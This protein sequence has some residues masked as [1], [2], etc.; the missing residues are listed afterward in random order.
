M[1]TLKES[2]LDDIETSMKNGDNLTK[3]GSHFTFKQLY[4]DDDNLLCINRS[5]L[6]SAIDGL[7]PFSDT[8]E[9]VITDFGK[10][11][12]PF[13][14]S[15]SKKDLITNLV[16]AIE[17]MTIPIAKNLNDKKFKEELTENMTKEFQ[18]L[19]IIP[20][21]AKFHNDNPYDSKGDR[22]GVFQLFFDYK[23]NNLTFRFETK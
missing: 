21:N 9:A 13:G 22:N 6:R 1:K 14:L 3:F 5:K 10:Y 12:G 17:N 23:Y 11:S 8:I 15:Q 19:G 7:H 20:A 18:K 16:T 2:L 4:G